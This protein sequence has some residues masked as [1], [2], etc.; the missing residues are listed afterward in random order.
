[1]D[2][3]I[4]HKD[5]AFIVYVDEVKAHPNADRLVLARTG[6]WW[7][8]TQPGVEV[9]NSR[10]FI[11]CDSCIPERWAD[12][13]GIKKYCQL[14]KAGPC[15]G[16][17]R[18]RAARLRSIPSYGVLLP[19]PDDVPAKPGDDVSAW[20]QARKYE[21]P[22]PKDQGQQRAEHPAFHRYFKMPNLKNEPFTFTPGELVRVTEKIHGT[23]SRVGVV[24]GAFMVGSHNVQRKAEDAGIYGAPLSLRC[25]TRLLED[26]K[27]AKMN[28]ILF[29]EIYGPGIQDMAYGAKEYRY[30]AF[31]L[32]VNGCYLPPDIFFEV[33][34]R[35]EIP[36]VPT[37]YYGT[38]NQWAMDLLVDGPTLM[39]PPEENK[40]KFKGREGIVITS[41]GEAHSRRIAKMVSIDY[42]TRDSGTEAH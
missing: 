15:E 20:F 12:E 32:M 4:V 24:D 31:D 14:V 39:C 17:Y 25:V 11:P 21:T 35:Y 16:M 7:V 5:A 40:S 42:L 38:F 2:E 10:L 9:G 3:E 8:C 41:M 18:I 13:W 29:G 36:T 30:A 22:A 6:G 33:M 26:Y 27:A 1:M 37:L 28:A 34:V 23:N 19:V